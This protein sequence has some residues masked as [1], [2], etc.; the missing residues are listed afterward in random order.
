MENIFIILLGL[1]MIY[2]AFASENVAYFCYLRKHQL[3]ACKEFTWRNIKKINSVEF[4]N[5]VTEINSTFNVNHKNALLIEN[6]I[7]YSDNQNNI[8]T[9]FNNKS[10]ITIKF[11]INLK[12]FNLQT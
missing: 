8:V 2:I 4:S 3:Y 5:Y 9:K 10:I 7:K 12:I 6:E 11:N 1:S